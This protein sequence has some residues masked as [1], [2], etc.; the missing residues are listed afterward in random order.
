M[1]KCTAS[2]LSVFVISMMTSQ[3][4]GDVDSGLPVGDFADAFDVTDLTGP[5]KGKTVCYR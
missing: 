5:N 4:C 1:N 3:L 2:L